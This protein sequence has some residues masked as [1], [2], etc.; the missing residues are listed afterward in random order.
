MT[1]RY[2]FTILLIRG[3]IED[4]SGVPHREDLFHDRLGEFGVALDLHIR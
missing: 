1:V 2:P 4:P 3:V